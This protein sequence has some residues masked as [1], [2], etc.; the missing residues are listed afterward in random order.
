MRYLIRLGLIYF[1]LFEEYYVLKN[2][3]Y[4]SVFSNSFLYYDYYHLFFFIFLYCF[5]F[6][7]LRLW[8]S[9]LMRMLSGCEYSIHHSY[10]LFIFIHSNIRFQVNE[11]PPEH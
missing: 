3:I 2:I 7:I 5:L 11:K 8:I 6:A 9:I 10:S 4:C 1:V